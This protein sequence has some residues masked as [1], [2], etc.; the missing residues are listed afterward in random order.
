VN[1]DF[2]QTFDAPFFPK[3]EAKGK[4]KLNLKKHLFVDKEDVR[5]VDN[6]KFFGFAPGKI[7]GLKYAGI[8]KVVVKIN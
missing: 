8:V 7:V 2:C 4:Y 5:A 3:D 1:E 6:P